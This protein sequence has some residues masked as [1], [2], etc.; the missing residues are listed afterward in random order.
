MIA[1]APADIWSFILARAG[2]NVDTILVTLTDIDGSSPRGVGA[3]MAVAADGRYAG[4]LSGGCIEAA[5]V[6]EAIDSLACGA[7]RLVR[8]GAGSPY[9]DIR[10]PCGSGIDLLF[11]PRPDIP[12]IERALERHR[13]RMPVVLDLSLGGVR[14]GTAESDLM[15]WEK[16]RFCLWYPPALRLIALGQGEELAALA[17]LAGGFGSTVLAIS[18]DRRTL[19]ALSAEGFD[20]SQLLTPQSPVELPIDRWT[21]AVFLFHDRDWETGLLT[22]ALET[23]AFLV[24]AVGSRRTQQLRREALASDGASAE[25]QRRLRPSLG[26]IAST[27]DP[28]TLALSILADVVEAYRDACGPLVS[29]E[30]AALAKAG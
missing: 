30:K 21:A 3:Q 22:R 23:D 24:G 13:D 19:A 14:S 7:A 27:R 6:A 8:F 9:I 16:G 29:W 25:A 18:P 12:T 1:D 20:T 11:I 2:E 4:S 15:R 26:L 17:R 10:L 28:A 5:V